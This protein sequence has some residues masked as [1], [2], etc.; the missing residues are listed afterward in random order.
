MPRKKRTSR[1]SEIESYLFEIVG[2]SPTYSFHVGHER[3][4]PG[5]YG[6]HLHIELIAKCLRPRKFEGRETNFT[7]MG[8]RELIAE[9]QGLTGGGGYPHGVG[10]L[11]LRGTHSN[12]LGSLPYDAA[13]TL[14]LMVLAGG[15]RFIYLSGPPMHRG[16]SRIRSSSFY[17][18]FE[19][20]DLEL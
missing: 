1:I 10:T 19:P 12:Y 17:R 18:E 2:I 3:F 5:A 14:P 16:S 8:T 9:T 15:Y 4:D 11:T 6:E 13:S 20:N 7:F